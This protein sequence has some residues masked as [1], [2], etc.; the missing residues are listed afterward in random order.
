M[1]SSFPTDRDVDII[2][3]RNVLI[4]FEKAD[5]A[6]VISRLIDHL[7]PGGYLLLGTESMVGTSISMRQV[8]PAVFQK[9]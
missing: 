3:L 6:A 2:F 9:I 1:A 7:R 8:A 5:Q 4:Y